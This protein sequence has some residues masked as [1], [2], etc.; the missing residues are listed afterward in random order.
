MWKY[1]DDMIFWQIFAKMFA[2]IFVFARICVK[3][4]V[5]SKVFAKI[6]VRQEQLREQFE[7]MW[8]LQKMITFRENRKN[9][10]ISRKLKCTDDFRENLSTY[11]KF[12]EI[13][14]FRENEKGPFVST[15]FGGQPLRVS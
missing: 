3:I 10:V 8:F 7:N 13:F 12:R 15:L 9:L 6:C 1:F 14:P 5:F 2:K 11:T 4:F